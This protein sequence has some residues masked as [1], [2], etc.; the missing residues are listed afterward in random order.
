MSDL[1]DE[2]GSQVKELRDIILSTDKELKEHIKWNCPSYIF[3]NEDRITFNVVNK[4]DKVKLVLH[5]GATRKENKGGK[6]VIEDTA[7]LIMWSSDIR[8]IITFDSTEDIIA[9]REQLTGI[10]QKWLKAESYNH[11]KTCEYQIPCVNPLSYIEEI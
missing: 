3:K 2:K 11:N 9:K 1:S 6:P 5:M 4:D 10:I 8:G 7:G